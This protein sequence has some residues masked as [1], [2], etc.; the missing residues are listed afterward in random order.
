MQIQI[1]F[2]ITFKSRRFSKK[3]LQATPTVAGVFAEV[4]LK[5][6]CT[7]GSRFQATSH[8]TIIFSDPI[9]TLRSLFQPAEI[10][11][12]LFQAPG[13]FEITFPAM[14]ITLPKE[15]QACS[16]MSSSDLQPYSRWLLSREAQI[17]LS[18]CPIS[19]RLR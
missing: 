13:H 15:C 2:H 11:G 5:G 10:L 6:D 7:W 14:Q 17:L 8:L 16:P 9:M 1:I 19:G 4:I 12:A 3:I 18:F